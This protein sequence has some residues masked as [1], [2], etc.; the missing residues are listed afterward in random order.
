MREPTPSAPI[1]ARAARSKKTA[2][3]SPGMRPI[4]DPGTAGGPALLSASDS[5]GFERALA[6]V[7]STFSKSPDTLDQ[8]FEPAL[9]AFVKALDV[10]RSTIYLSGYAKL[11]SWAKPGISPATTVNPGDFPHSRKAL[12]ECGWF[13]YT[14]PEE[15][16]DEAAVERDYYRKHGPASLLVLPLVAASKF[17]GGLALETVTYTRTWPTEL[18]NRLKLVAEL[19]ASALLIQ[20]SQ[21]EIGRQLRFEQSISRISASFV[22]LPSEQVHGRIAE[23]L[24]EVGAVLDLDRVTFYRR[25]GAAIDEFTRTHTWVRGGADPLPWQFMYDHSGWF[26][27]KLAAGVVLKYSSLSELPPKTRPVREFLERY[28]IKSFLL[29]PIA[30]GGGVVAAMSIATVSHTRT[31]DSAVV[32]R[33]VLLG[34]T[35]ANAI[36]RHRQEEV[37]LAHQERLHLA[38]CAAKSHGW[39]WNLE[40][41]R[42]VWFGDSE[43]IFG[44][45]P[46]PHS[47]SAE[48]FFAY[49]HSDD[50]K[51]LRE[52]LDK[53]IREHRVYEQEYRIVRADRSVRWVH[54]RGS[55]LYATDGSPQRMIG[56]AVDITERKEVQ[57]ARLVAETRYGQLL[58]S[59]EAIAWRAD[60]ASF[61]FTFV[62][63]KAEHTLGYPVARWLQDAK[64][65]PAHV[66]PDDRDWVVKACSRDTKRGKDHVLEYRMIAADG[67]VVWLHDKVT[68]L[69][70]KGRPVELIGIMVDITALKEAEERVR[71]LGGRLIK[72]QEAERRRIARE[73]HDDINQRIAL[74]AIDLQRLGQQR[75]QSPRE[76]SRY[77]RSLWKRT[78][79]IST[80]ISRLCGQLHSSKLEHLGLASAVR[81]L[82]NVIAD[83]Q[84][85]KIQFSA[86][87]VPRKLPTDLALCLFRV[88]QE[89][90]SN[91]VK[92]SRCS[93]VQVKLVLKPATLELAVT[94]NGIGFEPDVRHG[95]GLGLVSMEERLHLVG[96]RLSV[97]SASRKGT[98]VFASVPMAKIGDKK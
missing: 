18:R 48:E 57:A 73:L 17:F 80:Q 23:T 83:R 13:A 98:S 39:D 12:K 28:G 8:Q 58:E 24:A 94:D 3:L 76:A 27:R 25:D 20:E 78:S 69:S 66:H 59:I 1:A 87:S 60:P 95:H 62:S 40:T 50:R 70:K 41:G 84:P 10:E 5:D 15:L 85:V 54:D 2:R 21:E 30:V 33:L 34:E 53:S 31:W 32:R 6:Q 38:M 49:V 16:P 7:V 72:A 11:Y 96:G 77:T 37:V 89:A 14:S 64:F 71:A 97:R 55:V 82:C 45:P 61:R 26:A 90:L 4:S 35:L 43:S 81:D 47:R 9:G 86:R 22:N 29:I 36:V 93:R 63:S 56:I 51:R 19:F 46:S 67:R 79:A 68:V 42:C 75:F 44:T 52:T 88:C 74:V 65:W 92:H 91:I